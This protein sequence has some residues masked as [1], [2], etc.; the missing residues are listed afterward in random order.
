MGA[1][2]SHA[3]GDRVS[4]RSG[5]GWR[6]GEG[7]GKAEGVKKCAAGSPGL[8]GLSSHPRS[9]LLKDLWGPT[10]RC[11]RV[12]Q[13]QKNNHLANR[14][15]HV[16][17]CSNTIQTRPNSQ[18]SE[19]R[20]WVSLSHSFHNP[21][22]VQHRKLPPFCIFLSLRSLPLEKHIV[23]ATSPT[24]KHRHSRSYFS[25]HRNRYTDQY[26][27]LESTKNYHSFVF[28]FS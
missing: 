26:L 17:Q 24:K 28:G 8:E 4:E 13:R 16:L 25:L 5:S 21:K 27:N 22:A 2:G 19:L 9:S 20:P 14:I 12:A 10:R 6:S 3:A 1:G 15:Q 23:S 7:S 11:H 18:I